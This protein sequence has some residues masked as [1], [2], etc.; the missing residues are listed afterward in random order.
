MSKTLEKPII[1]VVWLK[2]DLRTF[3]HEPFAAACTDDLP[4]L[5]L[6]VF[7]PSVM[8]NYDSDVRHWRFVRQSLADMNE[9]LRKY[10]IEVII[11]H[12]EVAAVFERLIA[13]F[14]IKKVFSYQEIGNHLT[15]ARDKQM[16]KTFKQ[17]NIRWV[18][19]QMGGIWRGL[20]DRVTWKED[21]LSKMAAP[22]INP[23]WSQFQ[24]LALEPSVEIAL[25]GQTLAGELFTQ[26]PQMQYG[27]ET[28]AWRYLRSFFDTRG[29]DYFKNI[30]K[31]EAARYSSGR[32]SPYLAW[33]NL[34]NRQVF[35]F[36]EQEKNSRG[37]RQMQQFID[38]VRWR[39]HFI[40]K[41]ESE[42]R[43]EFQ[44]I[45]AAYNHLRTE[46][47]E[48]KLTAWKNGTTGFPIIDAAMRC[49]AATGYLNFRTRAM[50]VSFLTHTLWQPW[51]AGAG[52]LAKMFLDYEPGIHFP[53]FQM[54]AG[55]TGINT[56]RVY[57]PTLNAQ[58]HDPEAV[59]IKKWLPELAHL[60][61][62]FAHEPSKMSAMEQ[63]F[64]H[65]ELGKTYPF[66]IVDLKIATRQASDQLWAVKKSAESR[67]IGREILAKHTL[68]N[69]AQ[70]DN[71]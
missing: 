15:Y 38:R 49:V 10:H 21:F 7:E 35:H 41:F 65:F 28:T 4:T 20:Q 12:Q 39:D 59:F 33:G 45:N 29:R 52:H 8:A 30:S 56:I 36:A 17:N 23:Q 3:D 42:M 57:N 34:S 2:R 9:R 70:R 60:P 16:K 51:Q 58:K 40:Q 46:I 53:Q 71:D 32:I 26:N 11:C 47:D 25:R 54:Q 64:H 62:H 19:F 66:P 63:Q 24:P 14:S 18:E 22:L 67:L 6:Y 1:N 31:P 50:V 37:F 5:V 43:M 44:N 55:V 27:G 48:Q 61:A 13:A 68:P 69:D